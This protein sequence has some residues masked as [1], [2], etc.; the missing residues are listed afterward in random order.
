MHDMPA[1][2]EYGIPILD[3]TVLLFFLIQCRTAFNN[4]IAENAD[5]TERRVL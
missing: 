1:T 5:L 4:F 2:L 3:R